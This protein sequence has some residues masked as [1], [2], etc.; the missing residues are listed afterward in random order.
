LEPGDWVFGNGRATAGKNLVTNFI[1]KTTTAGL[2]PNT[3]RMR[4]TWIVNQLHAGVGAVP[5]MRSAGVASL[6]AITRYVQFV[7]EAA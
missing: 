3:Q 5:L 6:E 7:D 2:A 4:A 1:A